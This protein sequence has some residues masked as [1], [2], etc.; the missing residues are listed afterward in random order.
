MLQILLVILMYIAF[1][2]LLVKAFQEHVIKIKDLFAFTIIFWSFYVVLRNEQ[3]LSEI[4]NYFGFQV[5]SNLIFAGISVVLSGYMIKL[6]FKVVTLERKLRS[7]VF[8][9]ELEKIKKIL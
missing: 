5:A 3:L 7:L 6:H 1:L 9:N 8:T 4:A 2:T